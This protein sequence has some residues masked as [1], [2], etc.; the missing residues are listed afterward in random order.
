MRRGAVGRVVVSSRETGSAFAVSDELVLTAFHCV[1]GDGDLPTQEP[2]AFKLTDGAPLAMTI[3]DQPDVAHDIALLRL[4][5]ALPEGWAPIPLSQPN[6]EFRDVAFQA[7]GYPADRPFR[8]HA[9]TVDGTLVNP[10][11]EMDGG[12]T[13]LELFCRQVAAGRDPRGLSGAPVMLHLE[14]DDGSRSHL[15]WVAVGLVRWAQPTPLTGERMGHGGTVYAATVSAAVDRWPLLADVVVRAHAANMDGDDR[16]GRAM[17]RRYRREFEE[18]L[19]TASRIVGREALLAT[20]EEFARSNDRGYVHIEASAGIGKTAIA[21]RFAV[22]QQAPAF[23]TDAASGMTHP[24]QCLNHLSAELVLKYGLDGSVLDEQSGRDVSALT[25][26]LSELSE[27]HLGAAWLVVDGLDEADAPRPGANVLLLP[28]HLPRGVY[29]LVTSRRPRT[30]LATDADTPVQAISLSA[31]D[32][33]QRTDLRQFIDVQ[34]ATD[35][36]LQRMIP[37]TERQQIAAQLAHAADGNFMYVTYA[38]GDLK[39]GAIR[40]NNLPSGLVGYYEMGFWEPMLAVIDQSWSEWDALYRP[41]LERLAVAAEPVTAGWLSTQIDR[42]A[43][44]ISRQ[45]LRPWTRFLRADEVDGEQRWRVVHR[46][47]ADF[48]AVKLDLRGA[49]DA[50]ARRLQATPD[51][52]GHRHLALH[53]R[54]AGRVTDLL[55]LVREGGWQTAQRSFDPTGRLLLRDF[56]EAWLGVEAIDSDD[57]ARERPASHIGDQVWCALAIASLKT[58]IQRVPPAMLAAMVDTGTFTLDSAHQTTRQAPDAHYRALALLALSRFDAQLLEEAID[59]AAGIPENQI[60]RHAEVIAAIARSL[61]D[62]RRHSLLATTLARYEGADPVDGPYGVALLV[63]VLP[64]DMLERVLRFSTSIRY[65]HEQVEVF[66]ALSER[67]GYVVGGEPQAQEAFR[68]YGLPDSFARAL[69]HP[70]GSVDGALAAAAVLDELDSMT[71]ATLGGWHDLDH[72]TTADLI[73]GLGPRM[74]REALCRAM[75]HAEAVGGRALEAHDTMAVAFTRVGAWSDALDAAEKLWPSARAGVMPVFARSLPGEWIAP[76]LRVAQEIREPYWRAEALALLLH[77]LPADDRSQLIAQALPNEPL[78]DVGE[79]SAALAALGPWLSP[80]QAATALEILERTRPDSDRTRRLAALIPSLPESSLVKAAT[81]QVDYRPGHRIAR[82]ALVARMA[83]QPNSLEA[84]T[85]FLRASDEASQSRVALAHQIDERLLHLVVYLARNGVYGHGGRASENLVL[86]F[87][88][89]LTDEQ[90]SAIVQRVIRPDDLRVHHARGLAAAARQGRLDVGTFVEQVQQLEL[91]SPLVSTFIVKPLV[92]SGQAEKALAIAAA[93]SDEV[94]VDTLPP[95]AQS[96]PIGRLPSVIERLHAVSD[97]LQRIEG[98]NA[99]A[100]QLDEAQLSEVCERLWRDADATAARVADRFRVIAMRQCRMT[101][102]PLWCR[103]PAAQRTRFV[104]EVTAWVTNNTPADN[105]YLLHLLG[106]YGESL[107]ADIAPV[108]L[109]AWST[110]LH[111]ASLKS[112]ATLLAQLAELSGAIG[113]LAG[114]PGAGRVAGA[115]L[116]AARRW[117]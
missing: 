68:A 96:L 14:W 106:P 57:A 111:A 25:A 61:P 109:R 70:P 84:M 34:L 52:Y 18:Q 115:V 47:F 26:L 48:L 21:A 44:E 86:A 102:L 79:Q 103:I 113:W 110:I 49:H 11:G 6:E 60:N 114:A 76:A 64:E 53:L 78:D 100:D 94:L 36:R 97:W 13:A 82:A 20:M 95:I 23:F 32:V 101:I 116:D 45:V 73:R 88:P 67:W 59:A 38:L 9:L 31:D 104:A 99:I 51:D 29:V 27:R 74:D 3:E 30:V 10:S 107:P 77:R 62:D 46:S 17:A 87:A 1:R 35:E 80:E 92:A 4:S 75:R 83:A 105:F 98:F 22:L 42:P 117:P 39:S 71:G 91:E 7:Y 81:D 89:H 28:K 43:D 55:A 33:M 50:V 15:G 108:V 24:D 66:I 69:V 63:A 65:I 16:R 93:L 5:E 37:A 40:V 56:E 8:Q 12:V 54:S 112:R 58:G 2:I 90:F 72:V 41:V 19:G 85:D